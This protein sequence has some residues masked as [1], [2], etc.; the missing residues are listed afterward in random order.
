M[1][2]GPIVLAVVMVLVLPVI[3]MVT[4]LLIAMLYGWLFPDYIDA[5][6]EGSEFI[7]LNQ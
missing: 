5:E 1:L 7:E 2:A 3:F 6:N 4:G